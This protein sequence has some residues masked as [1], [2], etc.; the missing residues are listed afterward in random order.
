MFQIV[1]DIFFS[2]RQYA[3]ETLWDRKYRNSFPKWFLNLSK[4]LFSLKYP[5]LSFWIFWN[6]AILDFKKFSI[7]YKN[8]WRGK[9]AKTAPTNGFWII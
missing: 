5:H 1:E 6:F 7:T 4:F 3:M 2:F 9:C 8:I